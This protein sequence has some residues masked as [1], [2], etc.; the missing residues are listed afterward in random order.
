MPIIKVYHNPHFLDYDGD[1][2]SLI[3]P[4]HPIATVRVLAEATREQALETAYRLTQHVDN[5]WW[6]QEPVLLHARSTSVGDILET[7]DGDLFVV[8]STGFRPFVPLTPNT[9]QQLVEVYRWLAGAFNQARNYN[10]VV[11]LIRMAQITLSQVL[12][13]E[14]IAPHQEPPVF[15]W[16]TAEPGD[17]VGSPEIGLYRVIARKLRPKWRAKRLLLHIPE[18]Q[19]WLDS[20]QT[21]AVLVPM[22]K[23]VKS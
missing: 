4:L 9:V 20:P 21:W 19:I 16:S 5:S 6:Q 13:A 17:L 7:E 10:I 14:G 3:P 12:A 11:H 23:E 2:N 1:H 18:A 15:T 22:Q 8:E